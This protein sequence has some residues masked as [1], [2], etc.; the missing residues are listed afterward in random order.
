ML[1][2]P[3]P[4]K[5]MNEYQVNLIQLPRPVE[6]IPPSPKISPEKKHSVQKQNNN[7]K[8]TKK[9]INTEVK[10]RVAAKKEQVI[11]GQKHQKQEEARRKEELK[12]QAREAIASIQ[13]E[14][15]QKKQ[16]KENKE[17][18]SPP[19]R[20]AHLTPT[21]IEMDYYDMVDMAVKENWNLPEHEN[22]LTL[23]NTNLIATIVIEVGENGLVKDPFFEK[24]SG[25][26][27][28]DNDALEAIKKTKLPRFP[29]ALRQELATQ[30]KRTIEIGLRFSK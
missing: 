8:A 19:Y 21:K 9:T 26:A 28:F 4:Q 30:G 13:K 7:K 15:A 23:N 12:R 24:R 3:R 20:L 1:T 17:E 16:E 10:K 18:F 25:N 14:L 27:Q 6:K 29:L 11:V 5:I 2:R 22:L